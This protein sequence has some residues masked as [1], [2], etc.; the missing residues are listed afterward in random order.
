[1]AYIDLKTWLPQYNFKVDGDTLNYDGCCIF[2]VVYNG[3]Y[4]VTWYL[5]DMPISSSA[6][7]EEEDAKQ[8]IMDCIDEYD[9]FVMRDV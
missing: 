1:M 5:Q 9:D 6:F 2:S 3:D 4:N 7:L 8:F